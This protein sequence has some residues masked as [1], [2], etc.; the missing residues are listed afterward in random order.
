MNTTT[1]EK[2]V[3]GLTLEEALNQAGKRKQEFLGEVYDNYPDIP[4]AEQTDWY[5]KAAQV[6]TDLVERIDTRLLRKTRGFFDFDAGEWCY[7]LGDAGYVSESD[8]DAAFESE[9]HWA[10]TAYLMEGN[11]L[12]QNAIIGTYVLFDTFPTEFWDIDDEE[13]DSVFG[14]TSDGVDED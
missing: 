14:T 10:V 4:E 11:G 8:W 3:D 12:R 6:V 5:R 9:P 7:R 2:T 13:L 1:V